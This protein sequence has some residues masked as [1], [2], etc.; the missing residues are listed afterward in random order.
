MLSVGFKCSTCLIIYEMYTLPLS[1][2]FLFRQYIHL[3]SSSIR[4]ILCSPAT[5]KR[6]KR[7]HHP[8]G[9]TWAGLMSKGL[10]AWAIIR[11]NGNLSPILNHLSPCGGSSAYHKW[12]DTDIRPIWDGMW[13]LCLISIKSLKVKT[14]GIFSIWC[15]SLVLLV[16][17]PQ[18][19]CFFLG[20]RYFSS[21]GYR[22]VNDGHQTLWRR[23]GNK[24]G[25][26]WIRES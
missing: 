20:M 10:R 1:N 12:R 13:Y 9:L 11:G 4:S 24:I 7:V 22:D 17:S 21:W 23:G 8:L 19:S 2:S 18:L 14:L 16:G 25:S 15:L 26:R 5:T 6:H 3:S